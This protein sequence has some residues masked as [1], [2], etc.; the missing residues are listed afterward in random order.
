[1][2][3]RKLKECAGRSLSGGNLIHAPT[4]PMATDYAVPYLGLK[5]GANVDLAVDYSSLS[6]RIPTGRKLG[7]REQQRRDEG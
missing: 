3:Q 4:M 5:G 7:R 6:A 1:M 2:P